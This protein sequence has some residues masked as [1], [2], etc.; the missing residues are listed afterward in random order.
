[1]NEQATGSRLSGTDSADFG[2]M[3]GPD[4]MLGLFPPTAIGAGVEMGH[5]PVQHIK[6][7]LRK[8]RTL[9]LLTLTHLVLQLYARI[10]HIRLRHAISSHAGKFFAFFLDKKDQSVFP[11]LGLSGGNRNMRDRCGRRYTAGVVNALG[12]GAPGL[13]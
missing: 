4:A 6:H 12:A 9:A 8:H 11:G 5:Q 13:F 2:R 1:M 10:K 3:H 7:A